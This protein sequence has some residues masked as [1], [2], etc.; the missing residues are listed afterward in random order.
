MQALRPDFVKVD[1]SL[2]RE[3]DGHRI[4]QEA[5]ASLVNIAGTLGADVIAE[6]VETEGEADALRRL[7]VRL[8]QGYLF[9]PPIAR[10]NEAPS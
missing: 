3:I 8:A 10:S 5:M 1:P 9:A 4:K 6:G 7:G 2:V